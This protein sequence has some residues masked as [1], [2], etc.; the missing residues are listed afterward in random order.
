M[1]QLF[2]STVHE[3]QYYF[4]VYI[5]NIWYIKKERNKNDWYEEKKIKGISGDNEDYDIESNNDNDINTINDSK[6][7]NNEVNENSNIDNENIT[8]N[9]MEIWLKITIM[10]ISQTLL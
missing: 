1:Q 8:K 7:S 5:S 4:A 10:K 9:L 2:T 6:N 3:A